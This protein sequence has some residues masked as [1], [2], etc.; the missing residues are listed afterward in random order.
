MRS[1]IYGLSYVMGQLIGKFQN[2]YKTV[3]VVEANLSKDPSL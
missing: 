1:N 2:F 3:F